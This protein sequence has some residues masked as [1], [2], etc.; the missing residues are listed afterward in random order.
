MIQ[1]VNQSNKEFYATD[2]IISDTAPDQKSQEMR[3]FFNE[4]GM[5]L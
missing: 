2:A 3:I 1:D 5:N 4:V